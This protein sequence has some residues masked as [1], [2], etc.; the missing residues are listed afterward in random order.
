MGVRRP[1]TR[2]QISIVINSDLE[3]LVYDEQGA[4]LVVPVVQGG[5]LLSGKVVMDAAASHQYSGVNMVHRVRMFSKKLPLVATL[6]WR[7]AGGASSEVPRCPFTC[8]FV[9]LPMRGRSLLRFF[10]RNRP[11]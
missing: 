8:P 11:A 10:R 6:P 1:P 9:C 7:P 5:A 3:Q 4:P 2:S